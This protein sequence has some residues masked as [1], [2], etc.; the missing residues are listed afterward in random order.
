MSNTQGF[1]AEPESLNPDD[2]LLVLMNFSMHYLESYYLTTDF[3][4]KSVVK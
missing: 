4:S 3:A 1:L 2:C